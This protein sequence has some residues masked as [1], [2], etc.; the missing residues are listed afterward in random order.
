[1]AIRQ[2]RIKGDDILRKKSKKVDSINDKIQI[3]IDDMI[4][5]M[6][7]A[8]GV[9]LAAPQVG[10][11]KRIVVI[12]I[13]DGPIVLI[14]PEIIESKGEITDVEGCL[15]VPDEM[16]EVCRPSKI[17]VEYMDRNG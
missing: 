12:D 14:N 13:G 2:I 17:K 7:Q 16:G 10:L 9:G 11:L 1:M 5:T 6:Y 15:S 3:L 8:D 4:E